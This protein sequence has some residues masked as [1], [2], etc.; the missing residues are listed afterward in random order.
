MTKQEQ[1]E[2]ELARAAA[3]KAR[4]ALVLVSMQFDFAKLDWQLAYDRLRVQDAAAAEKIRNLQD[5][6]FLKRKQQMEE[7]LKQHWGVS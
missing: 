6:D 5:E 3:Q 2:L 7:A 1:T 4:D